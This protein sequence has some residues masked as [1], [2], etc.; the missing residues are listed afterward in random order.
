MQAKSR[1]IAVGVVLA[2]V[3]LWWG[4]T[5]LHRVTVSEIAA[6]EVES[7]GFDTPGVDTPGAVPNA[8]SHS[9]DAQPRPSLPLGDGPAEAASATTANADGARP[10]P[11]STV[12]LSAAPSL[13]APSAQQSIPWP[14]TQPS[15]PPLSTIRGLVVGADLDDPIAGVVV[16]CGGVHVLT[17]RDGRFELT[18]PRRGLLVLDARRQGYIP[19]SRQ[20]TAMARD[21]FAPTLYLAVEDDAVTWVGPEGGTVRS[22]GGDVELR[23]PPGVTR[24]IAVTATRFLEGDRLPVALPATSI[25]TYFVWLEPSGASFARD[26]T[27]RMKNDRGF[28]PGTQI[29]VGHFDEAKYRW[30]HHSMAVVTADG[31]WVEGPV[32]H[33]SP[34][35]INLA[36]PPIDDPP[37]DTCQDNPQDH[38]KGPKSDSPEDDPDE[39]GDDDPETPKDGSDTP[40]GPDLPPGEPPGDDPDDANPDPSDGGGN[41]DGNGQDCPNDH[42]QADR[43]D[44]LDELAADLTQ[45]DDRDHVASTIDKVDGG[46]TLFAS[47]PPAIVRDR[48]DRLGLV[49]QSRAAWPSVLLGRSYYYRRP[50]SVPG[51][52]GVLPQLQWLKW[53]AQLGGQL[54]EAVF[55]GQDAQT[56]WLAEAFEAKDSGGAWLASGLY[57]TTD[58]LTLARDLSFMS[59]PMFAWPAKPTA[60]VS[61]SGILVTT[62][63]DHRATVA[64]ANLRQSP[65]GAGWSLTGVH[66]LHYDPITA[67]LGIV[68]NGEMHSVKA[69][70]MASTVA[71]DGVDSLGGHSGD[72]GPATDALLG[73]L[74][75][76]ARSSD[77]GFYVAEQWGDLGTIRRVDGQGVIT[78]PIGGV[79][80]SAPPDCAWTP[81]SNIGDGGPATGA[82]LARPSDVAVDGAGNLFITDRCNFRIRAVN[83][84]GYITTLAGTGVDQS[85]GDAEAPA[86]ST[87]LSGLGP[88]T[89]CLAGTVLAVE[90]NRLRQIAWTPSDPPGS[91]L[92]ET[93]AWN[94]ANDPANPQQIL[95]P[96]TDLACGS[97]DRILYGAGKY[98]FRVRMPQGTRTIVA[99]NGGSV[100]KCA[101]GTCPS[102]PVGSAGYLAQLPRREDRILATATGIGTVKGVVRSS[103]GGHFVAITDVWQGQT[104]H[105]V[106]RI[107]AAGFLWVLGGNG[108]T[109]D[110]VDGMAAEETALSA[111]PLTIDRRENLLLATAAH[112]VRRI[113][114]GPPSGAGNRDLVRPLQNGWLR[115]WATGE[116]ETYDAA[117]RIVQRTRDPADVTSYVY[118]GQGR[119]TQRINAAG[120]VT[121][122][123]YDGAGKLDRLTDPAGRSTE[124]T[125]DGAGDL[126]LFQTPDGASTQYVYDAS[127]R[128]TQKTDPR[129]GVWQY[130][131]G[132]YGA[133][134]QVTLANGAVRV[135]RPKTTQRLLRHVPPGTGTTANPAPIFTEPQGEVDKGGATWKATYDRWGKRTSSTDPAGN[136]WTWTRDLA[137]RPTVALGP[138]YFQLTRT[139]DAFDRLTYEKRG[140]IN[141][142]EYRQTYYDYTGGSVR[143]WR[144][145]RITVTGQRNTTFTYDGA[146]RTLTET[147]AIGRTWTTTY[148]PAGLVQSTTLPG[149]LTT[150][151][152]RDAKGNTIG[153]TSPGGLTTTYGRNAAGQVVYEQSPAGR[154]HHTT[155]DALGRVTQQMAP[156]GATTL[157]SWTTVHDCATCQGGQSL[158]ASTT[159]PLGALTLY[160]YDAL[161]QLTSVDG[162][163]E[164]DQGMTWTPAHRVATESLPGGV[165]RTH[166]WN[167]R[168]LRTQTVATGPNAPVTSTFA[169]DARARRTQERG[170]LGTGTDVEWG[171]TK[172]TGLTVLSPL[173]AKTLYERNGWEDLFQIYDPANGYNR[174]TFDPAGR[175]AYRL[176]TTGRNVSFTMTPDDRVTQLVANGG[177]APTDTVTFGYDSALRR[178]SST[179]A[180]TSISATYDPDGLVLSRTST[181]PAVTETY[182]RSDPRGLVTSVT[183]PAGYTTLTNDLL[184]RRVTFNHNGGAVIGWSGFDLAGRLRLEWNPPTQAALDAM[185][186]G[187]PPQ[188]IADL[189]AQGRATER[190][191]G[192]GRL[193]SQ[194]LRHA[195]VPLHTRSYAHKPDSRI[196]S[197][198]DSLLGT[199]S[200]GYDDVGRLTSATY[201]LPDQTTRT[202][203]WTYDTAGNRLSETY[204][205]QITTYAYAI[206]DRL[207]S[208]TGPAGTTSYTYDAMGRRITMSGTPVGGMWT[209]AYDGFGRLREVVKP[210]GVHVTYAYDSWGDRVSKT[211]GYVTTRYYRGPFFF[212]EVSSG[213]T[214]IATTAFA[215]DG[216][217]PIWRLEGGQLFL[218]HVDHL[219]TPILLTDLAGNVVWSARYQP[220][221]TAE[222]L[223][224]IAGQPWRFPGQYFDAETGL[225]YNRQRYYDSAAGRYLVPDPIGQAGSIHVYAYAESCPTS[226]SDPSGLD[227]CAEAKK[228]QRAA[229][230]VNIANGGCDKG[231]QTCDEWAKKKGSWQAEKDAR[232]AV[233]NLCFGGGDKAHQEHIT[234][235]VDPPLKR[236]ID[237]LK[238]CPDKTSNECD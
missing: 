212:Y 97:E 194:E 62:S 28:A 44:P 196:A 236:C 114:I 18:A 15:E 235:Y 13:A 135:Y 184:G 216:S 182:G 156:G 98:V 63:L 144:L 54:A 177:G 190:V 232:I 234:K 227:A 55:V 126:T 80:V 153:V 2:C 208:T 77:G 64:V 197:L 14:H 56:Y 125:I 151:F 88:L 148:D 213:G 200:Y 220:F 89:I 30:E 162:P 207:T 186:A 11:R 109:P 51:Y 17:G 166:T 169:Y 31:E 192:N 128:A 108:V 202:W 160:T 143:P 81:P 152:T 222:I 26:V 146:G 29:P 5:A 120:D 41:G 102:A 188:S 139:Y 71:G 60:I 68:E 24:G 230:S 217:T 27:L 46:L 73:D 53:K 78:T 191:Y 224:G 164:L 183:G 85:G 112:R 96:V 104:V 205:G 36:P 206:G 199:Q 93:V 20:V 61:T 233:M 141:S 165:T 119:L 203:A 75:G 133:I 172:M 195:G 226:D 219:G 154:I 107:D 113:N 110:G 134:S 155:R 176:D 132:L 147:D 118:D 48:P 179:N 16:S 9:R 91:A 121:T 103:D 12:T 225:H 170:P 211:V 90:G 35:D 115:T 142:S 173:F 163:L 238:N 138:T 25:F 127:H 130:A 42:T 229:E 59:S 6:P 22:S 40:D 218:Y 124:V 43:P 100:F 150:A 94:L 4:G 1:P 58:E 198:T 123:T 215:A 129:G 157:S 140:K 158:L 189:P 10:G 136:V 95:G 168:N 83:A 3:A 131:Y 116:T 19:A 181:V 79:P 23:F 137:G 159:D 33:F 50:Y 175:R 111:G 180:A 167:S 149:S 37:C 187:S 193:L 47:P 34:K 117:G 65:Y 201:V 185:L 74:S 7:V 174:W 122:L 45:D 67:D 171:L 106:L 82:T 99:G 87:P 228:A 214:L 49:Y 38:Q 209:Y 221:G 145:R 105:H 178:T 101:P 39:D 32:R 70:P 237:K 21:V 86:T 204:N 84:G 72:Y 92:M 231:I 8:P 210:D 52:T 69:A 57:E 161:G 223:T 66:T 76:I